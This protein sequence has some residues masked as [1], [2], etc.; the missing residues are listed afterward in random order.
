MNNPSDQSTN[1]DDQKRAEYL[2]SQ[3]K[4]QNNPSTN[5]NTNNPDDDRYDE[6]GLAKNKR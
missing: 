1:A 4:I 3:L 6:F 5:T 2:K